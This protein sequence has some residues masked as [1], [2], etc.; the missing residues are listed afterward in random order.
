[1]AWWRRDAPEGQQQPR[2][3]QLLPASRE[4]FEAWVE[5]MHPKLTGFEMFGLPEQFTAR[6]Y[7]RDALA[8]LQDVIRSR[9]STADQVSD[10]SE[11][12]FVDGAVRYI[13]ETRSGTP[14]AAGTTPSSR[15]SP[16]GA[17]RCW[18]WII[19]PAARRTPSTCW[20]W[21]G[22]PCATPAT[23]G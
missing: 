23:T 3:K 6:H 8:Q 7:S 9:L 16:G 10:G 19:R 22:R 1:M 13:G 15:M 5:E 17:D 12:A 21:S 11:T 2:Q 14:A 18:S 4:L 20:V